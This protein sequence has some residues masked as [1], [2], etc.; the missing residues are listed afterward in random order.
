MALSAIPADPSFW[1]V[2]PESTGADLSKSTDT[3][4]IG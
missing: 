1:Y 3:D 2:T 4:V